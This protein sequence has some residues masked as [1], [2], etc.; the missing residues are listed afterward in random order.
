MA[1]DP[2]TPGEIERT[3]QRH[4]DALRIVGDRITDLAKAMVPT[5]LWERQHRALEDVVR[6]LKA[7]MAAGFQRVESTS[8]ER[9]SALQTKDNELGAAIETLRRDITR[10]IGDVERHIKEERAAR[11]SEESRGTQKVST[12]IAAVIALVSVVSLI[13]ALMGQG[14]H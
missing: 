1:E 5:E 3:F 6:D 7:D 2:M 11:E 9:K 4:D 14:G 12:W 8:Q 13:V 10:R